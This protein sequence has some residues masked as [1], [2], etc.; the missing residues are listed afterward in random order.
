VH[1]ERVLARSSQREAQRHSLPGKHAMSS[2]KCLECITHEIH[3]W[4][5]GSP[6]WRSGTDTM[7]RCC[8][9]KSYK[10]LVEL[11]EGIQQELD[12]GTAADPEFM[13]AVLR[14]LTLH[15]AK[16]RLKE[17]HQGLMAKHAERIIATQDP[18]MDIRKAMG[19]NVDEVRSAYQG[20]DMSLSQACFSKR[21]W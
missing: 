16:A 20:H 7:L 9:G 2:V 15:K 10:E 12:H 18:S 17:I 3:L 6:V 4:R 11:E 8:A 14:R 1:L 13:S 19:W 5:T 21:P